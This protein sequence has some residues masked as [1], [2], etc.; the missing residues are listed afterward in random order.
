MKIFESE[1]SFISKVNFVDENNVLVG[2]DMDQ[3]CCED[4]GWFIAEKITPYYYDW[5]KL[6]V[7]RN[8]EEYNFDKNFFQN[9]ES[10]DL[11]EGGM[12]VFRLVANGKPDLYLH[13]F[14]AH[15]GYYGHGFEVKHSGEI[16][17]S[18]FL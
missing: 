4:A 12:V 10:D 14:N 3:N 16:V 9:V 13:I 11:D 7:T 6:V 5:E 2:Y 18:D 17:R 15:N 1:E 8:L